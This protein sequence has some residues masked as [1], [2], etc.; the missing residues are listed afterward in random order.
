M[1]QCRED[2][3]DRKLDTRGVFSVF[4]TNIQYRLKAP[5]TRHEVTQ[6]TKLC[7]RCTERPESWLFKPASQPMKVKDKFTKLNFVLKRSRT[8]FVVV[9]FTQLWLNHFCCLICSGT[10]LKN[11][12]PGSSSFF[13][14]C[15]LVTAYM[16]STYGWPRCSPFL[17]GPGVCL[18]RLHLPALVSFFHQLLPLREDALHQVH[19]GLHLALIQN[20]C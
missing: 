16:S 12:Q 3:E 9:S 1:K 11:Q 10:R 19:C 8:L 17:S 13:W 6:K 2:E 4:K 20:I 18:L 5:E 14:H 7:Q 15:P